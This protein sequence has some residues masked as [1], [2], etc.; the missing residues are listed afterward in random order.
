MSRPT[1]LKAN[2]IG[3]DS[4]YKH[5]ASKNAI[6]VDD[7]LL[8]R[9]F[10]KPKHV[11]VQDTLRPTTLAVSPFGSKCLVSDTLA[12]KDAYLV[13]KDTLHQ[14]ASRM[15]LSCVY[16]TLHQQTPSILV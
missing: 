3:S 11:L 12:S 1:S 13:S 8:Q 6:S 4:A 10:K 5:L 15:P 9:T 16:N 7:T 2:E 14:K